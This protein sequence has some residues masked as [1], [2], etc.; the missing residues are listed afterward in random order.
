MSLSVALQTAQSALTARQTE[1]ATVSRNV[2]GAQEAGYSR[3]SVML[4]T[5][6]TSNGTSGGVRVE[7]ISRTTDS[8]L[9]S[10][11]MQSTSVGS[12]QQALLDGLTVLS[13]TIGDTELEMSPAAQLGELQTA[14]QNAASDPSDTILLQDLLQSAKDMATSLNQATETVQNLRADADAAMSDS[15]DE[16]N[17]LLGQ[18]ESLN[19]VIVNGTQSGADITDAL[20]S[21]DQ[22]LLSLSEEIGITTLSQA[23]G[24]VVVYTDSG[25]TL[26]ETTAREVSME[27]TNTFFAGTTG[28]AVYVDGVPI[29]GDN[30]V[31][32]ISSG[33]LHGLAVLRDEAAI[34]YQSQLDEVARGLIEAFAEADQTGTNADQA[35]LFTWTGG[36][37]VPATATLSAGL[38][39]DIQINANVDPDQ[40]GELD[41]LRDGGISDPLDPDYTYNTEGY[42][43]FSERLQEMLDNMDEPRVFDAGV[44]LDPTDSLTGF[45]ASSVSWLEAQRQTVTSDLEVQSVI[46]SR[47]AESLSNTTGVN[48]DE[49]MTQLLDIERAYAAAAKLISAVDNMLDDLLTAAG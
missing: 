18:L 7:G 48:I 49:E 16:I 20:D 36:P 19:A 32:P 47:T 26:F 6:L 29:T 21:R 8:G 5:L 23:D 44:E 38:A 28:N 9:Y 1:M 42:A 43:G 35:G 46:V 40:G 39:G 17:K 14:L 30:A 22:V 3:K 11:L 37:A 25:V 41:L 10:S 27:P 34:T 2:A 31:M 4:S 33:K 15:V 13:T 12:S 24:G 45:A